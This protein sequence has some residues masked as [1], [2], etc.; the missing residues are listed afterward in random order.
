MTELRGALWQHQVDAL[1]L[2]SDY[3][4]AGNSTEAA[5]ISMPTGTGKTAVI[6]ASIAESASK[7]LHTL[8][9]A[10]WKGLIR[11]LKRDL[12]GRVWQRLG[13]DVPADF[14]AVAEL[15]PAKKLKQTTSRTKPTVFIATT[16]AIARIHRMC[17]QDGVDMSSIFLGFGA[18]FVDEG[19]YEPAQEWS[20]ALRRLSLPTI[21]LTATPYRNDEIPFNI[22][23]DYWYRFSH[24][25]AV[26]GGYLRKPRFAAVSNKGLQEFVADVVTTTASV[27]AGEESRAIIRCGESGTIREIVEELIRLD[28]EAIGI[29]ENFSSGQKNL[30]R[31]VPDPRIS[32]AKFWVHQNKLIEGIDDPRFNVLAI[33]DALGT[34][35]ST[36][37]QIGR[38]LR[39][40]NEEKNADVDVAF[41]LSRDPAGLE[42]VWLNYLN[43]DLTAASSSPDSVPE[44]VDRMITAQPDCIYNTGA[45]RNRLDPGDETLWLD[46]N[47]RF[48][49]RV[50]RLG[51]DSPSS[52]ALDQIIERFK[53][54]WPDRRLLY[55][56]RP[57]SDTIVQPYVSL[58]NSTLLRSGSFLEPEFGYTVI[59]VVQGLIFAYDTQD[60]ITRSITG[61]Y[62]QPEYGHLTR[63]LPQGES[64]YL[65]SV[66]LVNTD[67]NRRSARRRSIH[68]AAIE[69]LAPELADYAYICSTA[70]GYTQSLLERRRRYVGLT[71]ARIRDDRAASCTFEEYREWVDGVALEIINDDTQRVDAF[72]R[73][74]PDI[75]SPEDPQPR[76]ILIDIDP[77]GFRRAADDAPLVIT[78]AAATIDNG[79]FALEVNGVEYD[80]KIAWDSKRRRFD[81]IADALRRE[82][83][84]QSRPGGRELVSEINFNQSIRVVTAGNQLYSHGA[85]FEPVRP[86]EDLERYPLLDILC[87]V[88]SLAQVV[89]E[90]GLEIVD[91]EWPLDSVFGQISALAVPDSGP[92]QMA[93]LFPDIEFLL[94]TDMGTEVADFIACQP[95]RVA[96]IHAKQGHSK[97]SASALHEV[98]GQ[99]V[100][101]LLHLQPM[102]PK[103][104]P[105]NMWTKDW[106]SKKTTKGSASRLRCGQAGSVDDWWL[107]IKNVITDPQAD[108]EVWI[109]LGN[110]LSLRA[111]R[112]GAKKENKPAELVQIYSLLQSAWSA[113]M[114]VG[115]RL[116]VFCSP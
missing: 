105:Q 33:Y 20:V 88:P 66:S 68:A 113:S 6:A 38:V 115:A 92:E 59:R 71:R 57:D 58:N 24:H 39:N 72:D 18:V 10:P 114:Q 78:D 34:D 29:H 94:C 108:R 4:A 26:S 16:A 106:Q 14:P 27:S 46:L 79:V 22:S 109:V 89:S 65:T 41:V 98:V 15:G 47:Y 93:R 44:I 83:Y 96:F 37:Q 74:A 2:V 51:V 103:P 12:K 104:P 112:D 67:I 90:K 17:E 35:R 25:Q 101:N 8:V 31:S 97:L 32:T 64:N 28:Y 3:L 40:P 61:S 70:E 50:F 19:H 42:K 95:G 77:T 62:S 81:I 23:P 85:F 111:V 43:F 11:Q 73:Y 107:H 116:R 48:A 99:A 75:P 102:S 84:R 13:V 36:I 7:D 30:L 91:D 87:A 55:P 5:L 80:A 63:L 21:L 110:A 49:A 52:L 69:D 9:V 54:E 76:H 82:S 1:N 60:R 53:E 86:D 56:G 100:K 45:F